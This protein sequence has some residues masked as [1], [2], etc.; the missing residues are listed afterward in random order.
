MFRKCLYFNC[1]HMNWSSKI[2]DWALYGNLLFWRVRFFTIFRAKNLVFWTFQSYCVQN[3]FRYCVWHKIE[4]FLLYSARQVKMFCQ[5]WNISVKCFV[6][7]EGHFWRFSRRKNVSF[8][9]YKIYLELLESVCTMFWY[10]KPIFVIILI[11]KVSFEILESEKW[12]YFRYLEG[13]CS[14]L[15]GVLNLFLTNIQ[16]GVGCNSSILPPFRTH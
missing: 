8:K 5:K 13:V 7:R 4:Q 15:C 16:F 6:L 1:Q 3:A 14:G 11:H 10:H 12:S 2:D 9:F